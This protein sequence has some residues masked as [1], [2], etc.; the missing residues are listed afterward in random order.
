MEKLPH[1]K[2]PCQDCPF[3]IDTKQGWLGE[4]RMKDTLAAKSFVCHKTLHHTRQ[5]CAGLE[6]LE[7]R[8]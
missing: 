7:S 2:R 8:Q 5:Q 3:R 4:E 1:M 6:R